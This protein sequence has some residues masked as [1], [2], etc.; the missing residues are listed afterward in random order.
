MRPRPLLSVEGLTVAF[1]TEEGPVRVVEDVTFA[2][3]EAET[4]GLVGESGCGKSVTAQSIMRLLPTPPAR[5]EAGRILFEGKEMTALDDTAMRRLRGDRIGMIFQEPM[6]SLNPTMTVGGQI[7]EVLRYHR[8]MG[9]GA[10]RPLVI[11]ILRRVGVGGAERRLDQYPH[12]LSGGLRQRVMIAM[13]LICGPKLLIADEPTTALDVTIQAQI[14]ELLKQLQR[15]MGLSILLIT[16]DLGVVAEMCRSVVVMYAGRVAER[17]PTGQILRHPRH[18]YTAGLLA[19]SPRLAR[20]GER[21]S[22]IPGS[23]PAP[24]RRQPGCAFADRCTRAQ[25]R[26]RREA[27]PLTGEEG[28]QAYA[29]WHPLP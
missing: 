12:Q 25:E 8:N 2:I 1:N 15:E 23:V 29:C 16:H 22:T 7:A 28:G 17:G 20:R 27:P 14:L 5:V 21:L 11:D 3:D 6:T 9:A 24:G 18:P 4:M 26:C 13:A 10:A 19:A